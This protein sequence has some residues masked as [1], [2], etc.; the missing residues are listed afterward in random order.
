MATR[1]PPGG[2]RP[3]FVAPRVKAPPPPPPPVT[4]GRGRDPRAA[5][6]GEGPAQRKPKSD[7]KPAAARPALAP[8]ALIATGK[9][10]RIRLVEKPP[11]RRKQR[12]KPERREK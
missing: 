11:P 10:G 4:T 12:G 6:E 2:D 8:D 5:W 3:L 7:S 1:P 9:P